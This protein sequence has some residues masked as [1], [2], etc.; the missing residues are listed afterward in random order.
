MGTR[1]GCL[2][3][4]LIFALAIEHLAIAIL[5]HPDISGYNKAYSTYKFCMY[6]DVVLLFLTNPM[7][8]LPNLL[9]TLKI[10]SQIS[11]LSVNVSKS[12]AFPVGFVPAELQS[13]KSLFSFTS[14]IHHL[15]ILIKF[16]AHLNRFKWNDKPPRFS[17]EALYCSNRLV[18]LGVPQMW[19]YYLASRFTQ[20]AQWSIKNSRVPWVRFEQDFIAPFYLLGLLW[21]SK[22]QAS[23]LGSLNQVP[24]C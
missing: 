5:Q 12:M 11:G 10:F 21:S 14:F 23:A 8:T 24:T 2:L 9:Q 17:R 15:S 13:L 18:G 7:I 19:L 16:K 20:L 4:L 22:S 6:A 1:Q 3:S